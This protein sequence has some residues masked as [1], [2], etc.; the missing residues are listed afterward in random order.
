M[1][2]TSVVKQ[3]ASEKTM[4]ILLGIFAV[5]GIFAIAWNVGIDALLDSLDSRQRDREHEAWRAADRAV[6]SARENC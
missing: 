3:H 6:R 4:T 1:A 2:Y 5:L